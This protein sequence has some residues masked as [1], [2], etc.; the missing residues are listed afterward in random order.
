MV[1]QSKKSRET[2]K[3]VQSKSGVEIIRELT[4]S[5]KG[6]ISEQARLYTGDLL[7][8]SRALVNGSFVKI[9]IGEHFLL[10]TAGHVIEQIQHSDSL[11]AISQQGQIPLTRFIRQCRSDDGDDVGLL[12]ADPEEA[13]RIGPY[14]GAEAILPK[15]DKRRPWSV[16]AVG[17]PNQTHYTLP[18]TL[19]VLGLCYLTQLVPTRK[20]PTNLEVPLEVSR[21]VIVEYAAEVLSQVTSPGRELATDRARLRASP[22]PSGSSGGGMWL[23]NI[24]TRKGSGIRHGDVRLIAI[25]VAFLSKSRLLRGIAIGHWLNLVEDNYPDLANCI[26]Q[27]RKNQITTIPSPACR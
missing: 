14:L 18:K 5:E 4:D 9:K 25:T 13:M 8:K 2:K 26:G 20:W 6:M 23:P 24:R 7:I 21:D 17:F 15:Y 16:L 1:R 11:F 10:A 3:H 27:I 12:E 22:N 19:A